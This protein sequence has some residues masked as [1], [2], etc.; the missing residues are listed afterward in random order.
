MMLDVTLIVNGLNLS[1]RLATYHTTREITYKKVVVTMDGREHPYPGTAKDVVSF[2]LLPMTDAEGAEVY[3]ALS[4][5]I[6]TATYTSQ[7]DRRDVTKTVRIISNLESNFL[8]LSVDGKR[9]Y[10][11]GEIQLRE[12]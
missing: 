9:R 12:L 2:T 8:L 11:G 4:P 7:Y 10:S 1:G 6:Y 5:L 3:D